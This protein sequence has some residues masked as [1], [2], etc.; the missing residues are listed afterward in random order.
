M[1][2]VLI[3]L[4]FISNKDEEKYLNNTDNQA[5]I[6]RAI[7]QAFANY[8]HD[9]D[10]RN[11]KV[12]TTENKESVAPQPAAP[13]PAVPQPAA[14]AVTETPAITDSPTHQI[15]ESPTVV[16]GTST[17]SVTENDSPNHQITE[18]PNH[19]ITESP[20]EYYWQ[21]LVS[22]NNYALNNPIFK[23]MQIGNV[24]HENNVYKYLIGPENSHEA[25]EKRKSEVK[26]LFPD[27]FVV[28]YQ[29]GK[30]IAMQ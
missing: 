19:P 2:S 13:Q 17:S 12:E 22:K 15:T 29:N 25:I 1:P 26:A 16:S 5:K 7:Y 18:S 3:E 11:R 27:A 30:R 28:V 24:I 23:G 21:I 20:T 10:K 14:P 9:I 4:G 8:K 6:C